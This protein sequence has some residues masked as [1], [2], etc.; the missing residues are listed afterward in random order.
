[1][2]YFFSCFAFIIL[3]SSCKKDGN[4]NNLPNVSPED[5]A[6]TIAGFNSSEEVYSR[7]LVAYWSFDGTK[8]ELRSGT[9]PTSSSNDTY[10]TGGVRG[11]ALNLNAGYVYY[12]T[13]FGAF[14]T[15]SLK[16]FTVSEW[17]K[18]LNN[19]SKRTLIFQL[20]RPGMLT[21]N[22]NFNLNTNS[23]PASNTNELKIQPTFTTVGNGTQDN[24]NA[25]NGSFP[26][27]SP[28]VGADKWTHLVIT[29]DGVGGIFNI[30]ADGMKVGAYPSRGTGNSLF[31]SWEP[32]EVIIGANYNS[33]PGRQ[34]NS[35]VSFAPMTGQVD[36][37]R[38]YN[39]ALPDA[40]IIAL[41]QLGRAGK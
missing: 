35:D 7:N 18:I 1:M 27:L 39:L 21:G 4:P 12:A 13:Q 41:F 3:L 9:A 17:V 22:I 29:Y 2:K 15:D 5:Y 30:W 31:K 6:G 37:L 32:N 11:Q 14:R 8:N 34:V 33:I 28:K 19:G 40:F 24:I 36:E 38:I 10:A 23:F 25:Q 26:Y 20:A 16:S